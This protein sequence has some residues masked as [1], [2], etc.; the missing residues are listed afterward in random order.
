MTAS[1]DGSYVLRAGSEPVPGYRL[2]QRLGTG[3][4]GE[5]WKAESPGGFRVALKFVRLDHKAGSIDYCRVG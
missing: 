3:G 5:V 4:F 2:V 1:A